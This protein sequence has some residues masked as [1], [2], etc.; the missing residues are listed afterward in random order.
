VALTANAFDDDIKKAFDS[1]MNA[2][3][4]K[5]I[6]PNLLIETLATYLS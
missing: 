2:H 1:G 4:V 5:P 6:K 3:Q